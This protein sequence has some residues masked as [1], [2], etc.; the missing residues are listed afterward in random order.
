[1]IKNKLSLREDGITQDYV[2]SLF[3][4]DSDNGVLIRKFRNGKSY[5][6]PCGYKPICNGYGRVKIDGKN[7]R[8]HLVIWLLVN[9]VY[10]D[11]ELDHIDRDKTN[12]RIENIQ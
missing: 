6:K 4:Y 2:N 5:N 8:T 12:N 7:Y 9:G 3:D 1:M 11:G 10:P